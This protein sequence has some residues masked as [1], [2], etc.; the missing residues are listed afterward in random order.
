VRLFN[1][2]TRSVS[3]TEAG[4][5]FIAAVGPALSDIHAAIET[6]KSRRERPAGTLRLNCPVE[7]ALADVGL[8]YM[9]EAR[10][11]DDLACGQLICVLDDWM[12][13]SPGFCLYHPDRRNVPAALRA[14]IDMLR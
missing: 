6:T 1:R 11:K 7:A 5:Q 13:S 2:T 14:F 12:P 8:A 9:W 4:E 3:L 10:V